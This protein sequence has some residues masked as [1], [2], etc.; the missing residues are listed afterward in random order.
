MKPCV[1]LS[2]DEQ[3]S[4]DDA[5]LNLTLCSPLLAFMLLKTKTFITDD[6]MKYDTACAGFDE[7]DDMFFIAISR[8]FWNNLPNEKQ[9]TFVLAHEV[10]HVFLNHG[11]RQKE[12]GY[13]AELW[14]EATDYYINLMGMGYIQK[15]GIVVQGDRY[16]KYIEVPEWVLFNTTFFGLSADEIYKILLEEGQETKPLEEGQETKPSQKVLDSVSDFPSPKNSDKAE[17]I[18]KETLSGAIGF[19]T[20]SGIGDEAGE[21][22]EHLKKMAEVK[23]DWKDRLNMEVA[24][25]GSENT[26]FNKISKRGDGTVIY[27]RY[28]SEK[29]SIVFGFDSSGS[30]NPDDYA[31]VAGALQS[32]LDQYESWEVIVVSCDTSAQI[33]GYFSSE[34]D[35]NFSYMDLTA[36]GLGGTDLTAIVLEADSLLEENDEIGALI[37]VT[38]GHIPTSVDEHFNHLLKNY[39]IVTRNGNKQ[40]KLSACE[41][42]HVE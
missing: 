29:I 40:L 4:L 38:D 34:E 33:I 17:T 35:D 32:I 30:M 2:N 11:A 41:V 7:S 25:A 28:E 19:H 14:N 31:E 9:R 23:I 37:I 18:R 20:S 13:N 16:E 39:V 1:N 24:A 5:R 15:Y 21:L 26:T 8:N 10:L 36:H 27:P 6:K 3:R 42:I 12:L 22:I